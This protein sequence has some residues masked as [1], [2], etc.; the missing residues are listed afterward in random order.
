MILLG[1]TSQDAYVLFHSKN[2]LCELEHYVNDLCEHGII[3]MECVH[4][5]HEYGL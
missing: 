4:Y 1:L 5:T 3:T 2:T